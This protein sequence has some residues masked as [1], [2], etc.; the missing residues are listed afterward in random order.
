MLRVAENAR[1][2]GARALPV[3]ADLSTL[4]LPAGRFDRV[5]LD[6]PCSGTGTLRKNPEIRYRVTPAAIERLA[7]QQERWLSKAAALLAPGGR[8]LYSTCSLEPEENERV[9]ERVCAS[10]P[11][12]APAPLEPPAALAP[13]AEGARLRFLPDE[14]LD[15]FT[16]HLLRR[17]S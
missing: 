2:L 6:A 5:L 8:L 10:T 3:A 13:F 4:S 14:R 17:A 12:L 16:T 7:G 1:R 11:G 9:V 15:G